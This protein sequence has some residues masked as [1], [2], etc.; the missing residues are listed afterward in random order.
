MRGVGM[1]RR[2]VRS[3]QDAGKRRATPSCTDDHSTPPKTS[4]PE[5]EL[6]REGVV[7][8][9]IRLQQHAN[10]DSLLFPS[11]ACSPSHVSFSCLQCARTT[12][13]RCCTQ[14]YPPYPPVYKS[15]G[16]LPPPHPTPFSVRPA[17]LA[18]LSHVPVDA[19]IL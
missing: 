4:A 14:T 16:G 13:T 5:E 17:H 15:E 18:L 2:T 1:R 19:N 11:H 9:T 6:R 7:R 3:T 10:C 8:V 12:I